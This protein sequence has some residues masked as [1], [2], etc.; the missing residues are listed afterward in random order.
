MEETDMVGLSVPGTL[1]YRAIVLGLVASVCRLPRRPRD[2]KQEPVRDDADA[3]FETKVLSAVSEALNNVAIHAY[4]GRSA[5]PVHI[6]LEP[7]TSGLTIRIRDFGHGYDHV[8][9]D[10]D[11]LPE[12]NMGLFIMRSCMDSVIYARGQETGQPNVLTLFKRYPAL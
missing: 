9:Q 10:P 7:A 6:E 12:S 5:G 11:E 3:E 4:R 8:G 1:R 2:Q